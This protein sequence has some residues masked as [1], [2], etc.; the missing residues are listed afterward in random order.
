MVRQADGKYKQG[1]STL[2]EG[3]LLKLKRFNSAECIVTGFEELMHNANEAKINE[4]GHTDRSSH[5]ENL[6]PMNTLGAL[7]VKDIE[8]GVDFAI[9]TGYTA[10]QRKE[11]WDNRRQWLG[12]IV[13]YTH[14]AVGSGYDKPRFP[15]FKGCKFHGERAEFD[16]SN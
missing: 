15:V 6:V 4:T 11:I 8:S 1:R 16:M 7:L 12:K 10:A 13:T 14:F 2:R 3:I 5:K 9:G